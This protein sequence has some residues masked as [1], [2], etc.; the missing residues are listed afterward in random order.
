MLMALD[1]PLPK[2]VFAHGWWIMGGEKIS[3][4][5]GKPVDPLVLIDKYGIDAYR[6]FLLREVPFG[7]DGTYSEDGLVLRINSELANDLGNLLNRSLTMIEKYFKGE[8]PNP[9]GKENA[10][11]LEVKAKA[12]ALAD[13]I[14]AAM[15]EFNFALYLENVINV[16]NTANKYIETKAP[17]TLYK[18]NKLDEIAT[19]LYFLA[20]VLRITAIAIYPVMPTAAT[21]M[22]Q[23]LGLTLSLRG[24]EADEAISKTDFDD[25]KK[26]GITKPGTK[27]NKGQ[28]LFPRI[29][30]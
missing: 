8:V 9:K 30:K 7:L 23:Q 19:M 18:E 5:K 28:P 10:L 24:G 6:Y 22:W 27:I 15:K 16:V 17:W 20:E 14:D 25:M 26:W 1:L 12:L 4:S 11:D 21:N 2:T 3:K 29:V 13:A